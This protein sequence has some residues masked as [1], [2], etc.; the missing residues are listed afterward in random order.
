M[1]RMRKVLSTL[2]AAALCLGLAACSGGS[3]PN[4]TPAPKQSQPAQADAGKPIEV[5]FWH[6]FEGV[7]GDAINALID[8]YNAGRGAE[9]GIHVESVFQDYDQMDKL[10]LA[11]Q[12]HDTANAC[13]LI[14]P[15]ASQIPDMM[16][17]DW[18]VSA[19]KYLARADSELSLDSFY[20][21]L[22]RACT[23]MGEMCA[24]PFANS[25]ILCYY[26]QDALADAGL[27]AAPDTLDGILQAMPKLVQ[28]DAAGNVTRYGLTCETMR[29]EMVNFCV[30][31]DPGFFFGDNEGGRTAP[32]TRITA[33]ED[34]SMKAFLTKWE[35]LVQTGGLRYSADNPKEEFA[36]GL[37][38]MTLL[39]SSKI[40]AIRELVGDSFPWMTAPLPKVNADDTS[41][42]SLGGSCLMMV[43]RGDQARIDATWDF[44]EFLSAPESQMSFST[45]TGYIPVNVGTEALP[46]MQKFYQE[47]PYYLTALNQ[48]KASDPMA[49]EPFDL[50]TDAIDT[51]ID[52]TMI[53]FC[54][55][56]LSADETV[57]QIVSEC[58]ALLDE[59]HEANS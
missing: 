45:A 22:Q 47:N 16:S 48:M 30:S 33:G 23:Y 42:A 10:E 35:Q 17:M 14:Q 15:L 1:K 52:D 40:G 50:V 3:G 19:A 5:V 20:G 41:G 4:A 56:S 51:V 37:T 54:Q 55:G 49:Q 29:Y 28:K 36:Q 21:P 12:T 44:L 18:T 11:Y 2:A 43:D 53:E 34:G 31:Q 6:C 27:D 32:M 24:I 39:S 9:K 57:E 7:N 25:T 59:Y 8:Q 46:E 13:D 26:N 38:A 58:N